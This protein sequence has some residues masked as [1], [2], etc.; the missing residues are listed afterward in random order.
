[1]FDITETIVPGLRVVRPFVRHDARGSFVKIFHEPWLAQA[2]LETEFKESYYS[3]SRKNVLRGMHFQVPPEEHTKLVYCLEGH[4][5]DVV[6]DLRR[7]SP[8]FHR[9]FSIELDSDNPCG[10]Y[11]PSGCAHGFFTFSEQALLLYAVTTVYAPSSDAGVRWDSL[12]FGWPC[13]EKLLSERDQ[14]FPTLQNFASPFM[15]DVDSATQQRL[16]RP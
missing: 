7:G 2:G 16:A 12:D 9:C 14:S 11:V 15:F 6:V 3:T 1:M 5:L 8:T 10:I 13:G 4:V